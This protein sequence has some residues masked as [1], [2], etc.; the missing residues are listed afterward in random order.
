MA[1]TAKRLAKITCEQYASSKGPKRKQLVERLR[2]CLDNADISDDLKK[3]ARTVLNIIDSGAGGSTDTAAD[4]RHKI[5]AIVW[6]ADFSVR[7]VCVCI[8]SVVF[9]TS[10][11]LPNTRVLKKSFGQSFEKARGIH[12]CLSLLSLTVPGNELLCELWT[13]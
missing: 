5:E 12:C 13:S 9:A 3:G 10:K 8:A 6:P 1:L 4:N 11:G 7:F 2:A